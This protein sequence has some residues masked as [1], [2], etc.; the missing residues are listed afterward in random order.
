MFNLFN[1]ERR[2]T[3]TEKKASEWMARI[4]LSRV[5]LDSR[6][7]EPEVL[8]YFD[9]LVAEF[10]LKSSTATKTEVTLAEARVQRIEIYAM[11]IFLFKDDAAI[12]LKVTL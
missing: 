1:K 7:V 3:F 8:K 4:D 2:A 10:K 9:I 6:G 5:H 12:D 11:F